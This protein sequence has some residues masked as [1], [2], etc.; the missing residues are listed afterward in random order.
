MALFERR[1]TAVHDV[2]AVLDMVQKDELSK[3]KTARRLDTSWATIN[4][5]LDRS[6]LYGL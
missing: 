4:R 1:I 2:T 3:R 5:A 6:E